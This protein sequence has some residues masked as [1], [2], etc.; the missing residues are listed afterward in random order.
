MG[1]YHSMALEEGALWTGA[2]YDAFV[3]LPEWVGPGESSTPMRICIVGNAAG[4]M[5]E[6]LHRHHD[7]VGLRID[8]I[9]IDPAVT[10]ASRQAMGLDES[11]QPGLRIH[12]VD[13]RTFLEGTPRGHYD[14]I[15]LDAYAR[16][17][18]IPAALATR[19]F[20]ALAKSRL[21]TGGYCFLNL[22]A[23]RPGSRLVEVVAD[24]MAAGF[25]G[26]V[27]RCP[28]DGQSNVLLVARHGLLAEPPP[29]DTPLQAAAS[30]ALHV[31]TGFVLTDDFC[32][33]ESLTADDLLL[34]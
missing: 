18:S 14:A 5:S 10:L 12:H 16:Q 21:R 25:E 1:T 32:P 11:T 31:P 29:S 6:L 22:G 17:V 15:V 30:F 19:E 9:E 24:T 20:F 26:P 7:S 33:V 2:Y 13:G 34:R 23:L 28:L 8:G 27:Y 3:R 4:T